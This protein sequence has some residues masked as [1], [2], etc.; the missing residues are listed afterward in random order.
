MGVDNANIAQ[1]MRIRQQG[2]RLLHTDAFE[3]LDLYA[4]VGKMTERLWAKHAQQVYC[5]EKDPGK[6]SE[7]QEGDKV[8][9][10]VDNN[11]NWLDLASSCT[12]VDCDAYGLV[13]NKLEQIRH[14]EKREQL[15]F[16]THGVPRFRR[17]RYGIE[18]FVEEVQGLDPL[19]WHFQEARDSSVLYGYLYYK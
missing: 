18:N 5:I 19:A 16:F 15:I 7:I 11:K 1:K 10:H 14:Y 9:V 4:G 17:G 2:L 6:A 13:V 3:V 12:V 8:N